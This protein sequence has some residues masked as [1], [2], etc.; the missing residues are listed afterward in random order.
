MGKLIDK[1]KGKLM[2]GE[3]RAT[4]DKVRE[5]QGWATEKKGDVEGVIDRASDKLDEKL[6]ERKRKEQGR[7][8]R[9]EP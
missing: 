1:I 3:G 4:G 6:D 5:A 7:P 9:S 8:L 2:K